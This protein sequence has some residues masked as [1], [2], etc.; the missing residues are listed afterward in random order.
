MKLFLVRHGQSE[1]NVD[2]TK[3]L[4]KSDSE[5]KLTKLGEEQAIKAAD[6]I[7]DI[8]NRFDL[9]N[10]EDFMKDEFK[11]KP[12]SF[13]VFSS[14]S[15]RAYDTSDLVIEQLIRM[16]QQVYNTTKMP[17]LR[18]R[19]WGNLREIGINGKLEDKH[20]DFYY[21]PDNGESFARVQERAIVFHQHLINN[22]RFKY[23]FGNVIIVGHGEFIKTYMMYLLGW[24]VEEFQNLRSPRNGEVFLIEDN[25]LSSLT[26]LPK[27]KHGER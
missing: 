4:D 2:N 17:I 14:T 10:V 9:A 23:G 7:V 5:I 12:H 18:E 1:G 20:F 22:P 15:K 26:P 8:L 25:E 11:S 19:H 24:S 6:K 21:T 16:N 13:E 27:K 3:Y